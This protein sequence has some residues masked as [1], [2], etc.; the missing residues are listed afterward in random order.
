M[1]SSSSL[2]ALVP[3][4]VF[5]IRHAAAAGQ[6]RRRRRVIQSA[7]QP[8]CS[9]HFTSWPRKEFSVS[10]S[11]CPS[12]PLAA[13]RPELWIFFCPGVLFSKVRSPPFRIQSG[14]FQV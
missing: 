13:P 6:R 4:P 1:F 9:V 5:A 11:S 8:S 2:Y 7:G 12:L 3:K 14:V 10:E